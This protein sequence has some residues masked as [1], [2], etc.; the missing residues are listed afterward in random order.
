M[1]KKE[2]ITPGVILFSGKNKKGKANP[3]RE[4]KAGNHSGGKRDRPPKS[5]RKAIE[6]REQGAIGTVV[7]R[8]GEKLTYGKKSIPQKRGIAE[9]PVR[10][11]TNTGTS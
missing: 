9:V 3:G 1:K 4:E 8:G 7:V 10:N 6:R 5:F 2:I 11:P